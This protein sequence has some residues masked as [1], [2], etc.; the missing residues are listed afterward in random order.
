MTR[1]VLA[2]SGIGT[3]PGCACAAAVTSGLPASS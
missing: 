3:S 1:L 2:E